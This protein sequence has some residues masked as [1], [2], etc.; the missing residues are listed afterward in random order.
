MIKKAHAF[1]ILA[2]LLVGLLMVGCS[3]V[4]NK[5]RGYFSH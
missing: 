1:I 4:E 3:V 5:T 2:V